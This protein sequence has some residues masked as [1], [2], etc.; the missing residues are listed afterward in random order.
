MSD[1]LLEIQENL[2]EYFEDVDDKTF[3]GFV[4]CFVYNVGTK[5]SKVSK[6]ST[7]FLE[8]QDIKEEYF[9]YLEEINKLA[10]SLF[11]NNMANIEII[12]KIKQSLLSLSHNRFRN[13][14]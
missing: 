5:D 13:Y 9:Q 11:I 7:R 6:L 12:E 10:P 3:V 4:D 2:L 1:V 14:V 8:D